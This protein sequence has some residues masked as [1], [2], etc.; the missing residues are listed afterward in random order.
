LWRKNEQNGELLIKVMGFF[1]SL[2]PGGKISEWPKI[3]NKPKA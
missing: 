2:G 1:T 3:E